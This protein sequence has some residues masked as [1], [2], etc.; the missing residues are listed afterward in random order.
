LREFK[1]RQ[2]ITIGFLEGVAGAKFAMMEVAKFIY[3][4]F[5]TESGEMRHYQAAHQSAK[6][7]LLMD[8]AKTICTDHEINLITNAGGNLDMT[9]PIVY[10]IKLLVRQFSFPCLKQASEKYPW[11]IPEGFRTSNLVSKA[12]E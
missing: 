3:A 1:S 8:N 5:S 10:L 2:S 11:L 4:H 9:G 7:P 12:R 6:S